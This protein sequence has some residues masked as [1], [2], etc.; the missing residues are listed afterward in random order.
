MKVKISWYSGSV[1]FVNYCMT[2]DVKT[3]ERVMNVDWLSILPESEKER[4]AANLKYCIRYIELEKDKKYS[5]DYGS[6]S[7]FVLLEEVEDESNI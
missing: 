1:T 4:Y 5:I 6:Y 2:S 7:K 3:A